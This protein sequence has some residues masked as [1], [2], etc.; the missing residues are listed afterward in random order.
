MEERMEMDIAGPFEDTKIKIH[1]KCRKI[2][3]VVVY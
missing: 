3:K 1:L 2:I